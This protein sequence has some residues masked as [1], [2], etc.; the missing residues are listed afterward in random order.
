M[1][2]PNPALHLTQPAMQV[3]EDSQL[4]HAGRAGELGHS[5]A[6]GRGVTDPLTHV[7][8]AF[9][10]PF[11][12]LAAELARRHPEAHFSVQGVPFGTGAYLGHMLFVECFWP[13]RGPDD[14]DNVLLEVEL[15]HL[16]TTP[17]VNADI[18]WGHGP[19]EAEFASGWASDDDWPEATS[20]VLEQ[21]SARMPELMDEFRRV[22]ARGWPG[23]SG[24]TEP[25][26]AADPR[27]FR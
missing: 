25:P 9:D 5:A 4:A 12:E 18:C 26:G 8:G 27:R 10:R 15:C 7:L 2:P 20:A 13:G 17:R 6:G 16:A 19:V 3:L 24:A 22:V 1:E 23:E 21:L 14:P 11:R